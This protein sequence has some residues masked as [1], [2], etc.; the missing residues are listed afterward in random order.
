M[1]DSLMSVSVYSAALIALECSVGSLLSALNFSVSRLLKPALF[2]AIVHLF[3]LTLCTGG[4]MAK[5][6]AQLAVV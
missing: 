4:G 6:P 3:Q 2:L 1:N 5:C